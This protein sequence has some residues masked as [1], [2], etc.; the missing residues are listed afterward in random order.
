MKRCFVLFLS[1]LLCLAIAAVIENDSND[2]SIN[3]E[4]I[5]SENEVIDEFVNKQPSA[6]NQHAKSM[7]SIE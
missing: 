7:Y 5:L 6:A 1:L 2:S 3:N 4:H